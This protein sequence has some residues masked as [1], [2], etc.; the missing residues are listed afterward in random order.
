MASPVQITTVALDDEYHA[1]ETLQWE[2]AGHCPNVNLIGAF[3]DADKARDFCNQHRPDLLLLDVDLKVKTGFDFLQ[4]LDSKSASIIFITAYEEYALR[5]FEVA[6]TA[7]L[8]KPVEGQKLAA[9]VD[10]V[11][12]ARALENDRSR[13]EQLVDLLRL[14][15]KTVTKVPL[16]VSDGLRFV[17]PHD[18]MYVAAEGNYTNIHLTD[19]SKMLVS[20]TMRTIQQLI[21]N[22]DTFLRIHKSHVVNRDFIERY[23]RSDGGFVQL[24]NGTQLSVGRRYK[25]FLD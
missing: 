4:E 23:S 19:G 6:A 12:A 16:P 9:A 13:I 8:L 20:K 3:T 7:Y 10:R 17:D 18:I 14:Q 22:D 2:L 24:K 1:L 21:G 25:T 5:A 11:L 15:A